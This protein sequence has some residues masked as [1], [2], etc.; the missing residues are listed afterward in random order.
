MAARSTRLFGERYVHVLV[1]PRFVDPPSQR[2]GAKRPPEVS[3]PEV[4]IA[5]EPA[6]RRCWCAVAVD[7]DTAGRSAR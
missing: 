6:R 3:E 4:E 1:G 2:S 7:Q 5:R